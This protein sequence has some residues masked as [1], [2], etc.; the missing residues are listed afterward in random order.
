MKT[1]K[2]YLRILG[3]LH[4]MKHAFDAITDLVIASII[5]LAM[6]AL[7][8][9]SISVI[10]ELRIAGDIMLG[11]ITIIFF[12]SPIYGYF[13]PKSILAGVQEKRDDTRN[14]IIHLE[15]ILQDL[16]IY[17][18]ETKYHYKEN[19]TEDLTHAHH[20]DEYLEIL[21]SLSEFINNEYFY[22]EKDYS[23]RLCPPYEVDTL[24]LR[25]LL[26]SAG[27]H[28]MKNHIDAH[29]EENVSIMKTHVSQLLT[30][31]HREVEILEKQLT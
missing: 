24:W 9:Q 4:Q 18:R 15:K 7:I 22:R 6:Y 23:F 16:V 29:I 13:N 20:E 12:G 19:Y 3:V 10:D 2:T 21:V 5:A 28:A 26:L 14:E 17:E 31:R 8:H 25:V 1:N 11:I 27:I 30:N